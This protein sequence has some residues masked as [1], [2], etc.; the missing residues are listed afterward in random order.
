MDNSGFWFPLF[1]LNGV[2]MSCGKLLPD[3]LWNGI[4]PF[5]PVREMTF[6]GGRP[7]VDNRSVFLCLLFVLKTGIGRRDLPTELE[8]S[9]K[10]VRMLLKESSESASGRLD[11]AEVLI[12]VGLV[13]APCG[14]EE[15]VRS[16]GSRSLRQ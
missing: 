10:T 6:R 16:R 13:K 9:V 7:P 11:L 5:L 14:G 8:A 2:A 3:E 1:F 15:S 12:D 4:E